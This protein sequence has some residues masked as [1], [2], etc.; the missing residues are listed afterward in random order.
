MK[1]KN[2]ILAAK[3]KKINSTAKAQIE[4][5]RSKTASQN[6]SLLKQAVKSLFAANPNLESFS[7]TEY[8]PYWN[9]GDACTFSTNF[10]YG[11]VVNGEDEDSQ[12]IETLKERVQLLENR[13]AMSAKIAR[14]IAQLS[15]DKK[16]NQWEIESLESK[17]HFLSEHKD[18]EEKTLS[19]LEKMKTKIEILEVLS[20]IEDEYYEEMFGEGTV[21]VTRDG[22]EVSE[23]EHE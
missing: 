3:I 23:C 6:Q 9:D 5:I 19:I 12:D 11:L 22:I 1:S 21:T 2:A 8:T 17:I 10:G 15:K 13:K 16:N 18:G 20:S 4:K 14:K 7:W